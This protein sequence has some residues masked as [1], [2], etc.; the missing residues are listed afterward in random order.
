MS[1]N[2]VEDALFSELDDDED[3]EGTK[4]V[5]FPLVDDQCSGCGSQHTERESEDVG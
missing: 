1:A 5:T 3:G 4:K 2:Y